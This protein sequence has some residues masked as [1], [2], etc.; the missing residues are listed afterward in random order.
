MSHP[1]DF[2][3]GTAWGYSNTGYL[4]LA[5][6]VEELAGR[7][8]YE[9]ADA[10][11]LQPLEL[12]HTVWPGDDPGLPEPQARGYQR[13]APEAPLSDVTELVEANAAHGMVSTNAPVTWSRAARGA[14]GFGPDSAAG[15]GRI[16]T[17]L[18]PARDCLPV[19]GSR[20][21]RDHPRGKLNQPRPT[22]P[23]GRP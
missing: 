18:G 23:P 10:R 5:M 22:V 21:P 9:E 14:G 8:W 13:F 3:P 17:S 20:P 16:P 19:A 2:A 1:P 15:P 6:I 4:L 7:P 11:I 12:E